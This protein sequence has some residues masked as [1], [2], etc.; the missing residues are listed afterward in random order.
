MS[1][2]KPEGKAKKH[3]FLVCNIIKSP[4]GS[5]SVQYWACYSQQLNSLCNINVLRVTKLFFL[6]SSL[7]LII[8]YLCCLVVDWLG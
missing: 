6:S 8:F 5:I 3:Y 1:V 4:A 2:V 7:F